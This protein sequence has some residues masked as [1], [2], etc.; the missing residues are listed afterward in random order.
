MELLKL[1]EIHFLNDDLLYIE[2]LLALSFPEDERRPFHK[3]RTL[4][5]ETPHFHIMLLTQHGK[6]VGLLNWWELNRFNYCEHFAISPAARCKGIGSAVLGIMKSW[7]PLILEAEPPLNELARR[8]VEFYKRQGLLPWHKQP[9][10]SI[11][12]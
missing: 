1:S 6:R 11:Q 10:I 8:R 3:I 7:G 12:Y 9:L 2:E 5:L 4:L